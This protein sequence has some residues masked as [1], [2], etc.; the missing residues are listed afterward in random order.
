MVNIKS[1]YYEGLEEF[2]ELVSNEFQIA[3]IAH[4]IGHK[5]GMDHDIDSVE[6]ADDTSFIMNTSVNGNK[7][8]S[9]SR[10]DM[11]RYMKRNIRKE[12][13]TDGTWI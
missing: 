11:K 12:C 5:L 13:V 2:E 9:C 10:D 8:S 1:K 7:F 6:C 3:L 4:E